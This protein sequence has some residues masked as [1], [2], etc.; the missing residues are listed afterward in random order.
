[1]LSSVWSEDSAGVPMMS[2]GEGPDAKG[3]VLKSK[4]RVYSL[5]GYD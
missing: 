2:F 4:P 1:M 3:R 5:P